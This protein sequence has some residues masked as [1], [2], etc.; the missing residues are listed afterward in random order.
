ML[1]LVRLLELFV[2]AWNAPPASLGELA[3]REAVFRQA[4]PASVRTMTNAD[5]GPM[6]AKGARL[7]SEAPGETVA[8][9]KPGMRPG[10]GV[11]EQAPKD[12]A[13]WRARMAQARAAVERDRLLMAALESRVAVLTL[14]VGSRDDPEQR[15][16]LVA[17]RLR[18]IAELDRMREQVE[19]DE[20][21]I[22]V[23]EEEA[24][25]EDVPP[26]WLRGGL[27]PAGSL[28]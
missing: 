1:I 25:R 10:G 11:E 5:L 27:M 6:P 18:T 19:A 28:R 20:Q 17:D 2:S 21:A 16:A 14:D 3:F 23:I 8:E 13:W 26:G 7:R 24:R 12:E 9:T 4:M 15:A 22:A